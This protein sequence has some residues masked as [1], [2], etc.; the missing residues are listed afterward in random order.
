MS[1]DVRRSRT[2]PTMATPDKATPEPFV[3]ARAG[4]YGVN[5]EE[6][7]NAQERAMGHFTLYCFDCQTYQNHAGREA[8][9][10]ELHSTAEFD[11]DK[12]RK[13]WTENV[14]GR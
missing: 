14:S 1:V 11:Y 12:D 7:T 13:R 8:D 2:E 4:C 6:R 10:A 5:L 3:C 9:W